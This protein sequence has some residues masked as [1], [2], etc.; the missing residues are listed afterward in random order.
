MYEYTITHSSL[1]MNWTDIY[2]YKAPQST[3][4]E[5]HVNHPLREAHMSH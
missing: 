4:V 1:Q 5:A 3:D 2:I